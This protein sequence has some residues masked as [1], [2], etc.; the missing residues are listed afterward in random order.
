MLRVMFALL[1]V[2]FFFVGLAGVVMMPTAQA[3]NAY[4]GL[5]AGIIMIGFS[6]MFG[7]LEKLAARLPERTEEKGVGDGKEKD[8]P[9]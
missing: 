9:R 1:G 2:L 3:T 7:R 4:L 5:I 6:E 8:G